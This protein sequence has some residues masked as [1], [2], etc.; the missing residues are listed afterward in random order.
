MEE[1]KKREIITR[2]E[3]SIS[4]DIKRI[5]RKIPEGEKRKIAPALMNITT[6]LSSLYEMAIKDE[7]TGLYNMRFFNTVL[8]IEIEKA[9]RYN[10]DL[11]I[12]VIDADNFKQIND[13]Y[14]H[15]TGDKVLLKIAD[16]IKSNTRKSDIPARFGGEEFIILLPHT[17]LR[18]ALKVSERIRKEIMEEEDLAKIGVTVSAG[19]SHFEPGDDTKSLFEKADRALLAAKRKGKNKS[20]LLTEIEI[21]DL[22]KLSSGIRIKER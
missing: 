8:E 6:N 10:K 11:S 18:K 7:K 20:I 4:K 1:E 5:G 19:I 17:E 22:Y 13:K 9:K 14:G 3:R 15:D 16:K 12:I 21:S 2:G